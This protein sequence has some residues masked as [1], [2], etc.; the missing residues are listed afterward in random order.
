MN[1]LMLTYSQ[2]SAD[3]HSPQ[4]G[5]D[6]VQSPSVRLIPIAGKSSPKTLIATPTAKANQLY[7][8]MQHWPS[9]SAMSA[10]SMEADSGVATCSQADFLANLSALP[11][12][13]EARQMTVRSGLRCSALLKKQDLL[14]SLART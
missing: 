1:Q 7:P 4:S 12:S 6:S 8:S 9:C 5:L 14:G 13:D 11:G 3:S 10:N 2:E